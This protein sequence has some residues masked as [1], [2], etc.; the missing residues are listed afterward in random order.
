MRS[1]RFVV[2]AV[3]EMEFQRADLIVCFYT[4]Q[5]VPL[6][7]RQALLSRLRR[8]LEPCGMLILFEKTLSATGLEQDISEGGYLEFKRRRGFSNSEIIEKRRSLRGI[9]QPLSAAQNYALLQ[10]AGFTKIM[11]VFRWLMFDGVVAY[12]G[13]SKRSG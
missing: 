6:R 5:F 9:L 13:A 8:A 4:L 1:L 7:H 2:S 3:E 11:H 12:P 10:R